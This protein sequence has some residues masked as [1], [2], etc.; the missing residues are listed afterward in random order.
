MEKTIALTGSPNCG[1]TTLFNLITGS[2]AATGNWAGVTVEKK[3]G[4]LKADPDYEVVD[5]PGAYSL[6]PYSLEERVTRDFLLGRCAKAVICVI[7]GTKP[8]AGI[9]LALEL[10]SLGVP[11]VLAVNFADELRKMGGDVNLA[12]L[13]KE[14]GFPAFLISAKS[15]EGVGGLAAAVLRTAGGAGL[16]PGAP[17]P[18]RERHKAAEEIARSCFTF[19]EKGKGVLEKLDRFL[20]ESRFAVLVCLLLVL[21]MFLV[22]FGFPGTVLKSAVDLAFEKLQGAAGAAL[23]AFGASG[24]ATSLLVDGVIGGFGSVISFLPQ[25]ALMFFI[26]S[27]LEDSGY[28]AR[29]AFVSDKALR[30]FGLGGRSIIPVLMGFGCTVPAVLAAKSNPSQ[31]ERLLT[32]SALPFIQCSAKLPL[33]LLFAAELFPK[34]RAGAVAGIYLIGIAFALIYC[35]LNKQNESA[36]FVLEIPPC[37]MPS[38]RSI[39]K[40][41]AYKCEG[42]VFKAGTVVLAAN[43]AVWVLS[44]FGP[45]FRPAESPAESLLGILGRFIAP[46]FAPLGIGWEGVVPLF[47]G[48]AAK[49]AG[50]SALLLLSGGNIGNVFS[51]A[52]ALSFLLF[53]IF[54]SPC[55]AALGAIKEELGAKTAF[56]IFFFQ[57]ALAYGISFVFYQFAALFQNLGSVL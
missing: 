16:L 47:C 2:R 18:E 54:Y 50:L 24:W 48:L 56:K 9:Y 51:P 29:A 42:F 3:I 52:Q 8:E 43:V 22:V 26:I 14:L 6:T 23:S 11:A 49:E 17:L 4:R 19:E 32:V 46:I 13:E 44:F 7:D 1:K 15:G 5:L 34:H 30:R 21:I 41:T 40:S 31:R 37:R 53:F 27:F 35:Y 39:I 20:T 25:T 57:T 36:G 45:G 55:F 28:M 33:Y 12:A 10:R 38:L